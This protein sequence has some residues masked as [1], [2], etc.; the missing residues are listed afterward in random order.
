MH[1]KYRVKFSPDIFD[2]FGGVN[3][4]VAALKTIG[5]QVPPKTIRKQRERGNVPADMVASLM[6]AS[7]KIKSPLNPYDYLLERTNH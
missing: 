2:H 1:S 4:V 6:L 3:G 5:V 7:L